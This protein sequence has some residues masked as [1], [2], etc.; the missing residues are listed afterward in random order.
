MLPDNWKSNKRDIFAVN[1]DNLVDGTRLI[2]AIDRTNTQILRNAIA[3]RR[4]AFNDVNAAYLL[5]SIYT[6]L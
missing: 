1:F 4:V 5:Q 3:Q 2:T 6:L